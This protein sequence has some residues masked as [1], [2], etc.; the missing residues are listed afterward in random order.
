MSSKILYL[1]SIFTLFCTFSSLS[2][3]IKSDWNW[4]SILLGLFKMALT[5][6][7]PTPEKKSGERSRELSCRAGGFWYDS[8]SLR[9]VVVSTSFW[10]WILYNWLLEPAFEAVIWESGRMLTL[11][12]WPWIRLDVCGTAEPLNSA[13]EA[14]WGLSVGMKKFWL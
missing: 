11:W 14:V 2:R 8:P 7:A 4:W 3:F 13:W 9:L 6:P 12:L 5:L 1:Y 10:I